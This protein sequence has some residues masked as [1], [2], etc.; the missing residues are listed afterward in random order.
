MYRS[1]HVEAF[2]VAQFLADLQQRGRGQRSVCHVE[3]IPPRPA[4]FGDFA[5]LLDEGVER[6]LRQR[7]MTRPY[8]HQEQAWR[9]LRDGQDVVIVTPTASGKT[10]CYSAP[11]VSMMQETG[12]GSALLLYP[13]KALAQDQCAAL[14]TLMASSGV[15]EQSY[16][17]DGDTPA[18]IRRKVRSHGRLILSNP[19]MLHQAILPNHEKWRRLFKT[20][21]YVVIDETHSYRGVFGSHVANVL[22]RLLRIC[23]HYG[24]TPQIVCTSATIAN[25]VE[26]V[27]QLTGRQPAAVLV[28]GAPSAGKTLVFYNPPLRNHE[29]RLRQSPGSA[30][31]GM[32]RRLLAQGASAIVFCQSRRGV[33][34]LTRRLRDTLEDRGYKSLAAQIEGYRGGYL[35]EER[36][37]IEHS[38]R[39]GT[40]RAVVTTNALELGV[41]IGALDVCV[42]A[43]YPG[44]I[45]ASWQRAGR[46]GRRQQKA[47]IVMIAGDNPVDQYMVHH[48]EFFLE[49]SPEHARIDPN[50]LRIFA[51]HLKCAIFELPLRFDEGFGDMATEEVQEVA[52]WLAEQAQLF[53]P[54]QHAWHWSTEAYPATTVNIRDMVD[55]NF[56]I[57][58]D[59]QERPTIV[60]EIDFISAHETVYEKAIYM[61]GGKMF[62]VHRLDYPNRKAYIQP[63]NPD[64]YTT[65]IAQSRVFALDNFDNMSLGA[66]EVNWGEVRVATR[67]VGY[68]KIR[69][70]TGENVGYGEILLPDIEKH[71]TAFWLTFPSEALARSGLSAAVIEEAL[72]G[73]SKV[74]HT[75]SVVHAM[76]DG[77]DLET[78]IGTSDGQAWIRQMDLAWLQQM[79]PA[80]PLSGDGGEDP[81]IFVYDTYPGGTGLSEKLYADAPQLVQRAIQLIDRCDCEHGCPAC[82]GAPEST[83][84]IPLKTATLALLQSAY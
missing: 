23:A 14:N 6:A 15:Q 60:G 75:V 20:L 34:T 76:C 79:E 71:T 53:T 45:A 25:P 67:Y 3:E 58:D 12:G 29:L 78:V 32:L 24:S 70:K 33:E 4:E 35:P 83:I 48:P 7:G 37:R 21:R 11:I 28:S 52:A 9:L 41:D 55:E 30:A 54:Q 61:H 43:G 68:K 74:L 69:F 56:V 22:R 44:T 63:V 72:I 65:A 62:E 8:C 38:L 80:T 5:G 26:L 31:N 66:W 2:D 18:D 82:V 77:G 13:T 57:I 19:D 1:E 81:A 16:V 64:Y 40:T 17:Y 39:Q 84:E 49:A 46:A 10:L 42:L 50:N 27:H 59:S 47:L 36:R 51:E 73:A